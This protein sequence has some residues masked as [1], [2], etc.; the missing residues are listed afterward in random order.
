MAQTK[1]AIKSTYPLPAYN[2][3]VTVLK[4]GETL[5]LGFSEISGLSVEHEPVTYKHG[6]SFLTGAKIIPGMRQPIRLTMKRGV[7]RQTNNEPGADD[8]GAYLQ[9]WIQDAYASLFSTTR[10]RDILIEL[11]D[12]TGQAVVAWKVQKALPTKLEAPTFD[13]N[14]NDVAIET[15]EVI[16]HGLKVDYNP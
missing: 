8:K 1:A 16:A 11:C 4:G 2:Y 10:K 5:V 6:L 13:A 3:R 9:S 15:M 14:S 12:E 7:I